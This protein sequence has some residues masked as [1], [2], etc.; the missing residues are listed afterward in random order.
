MTNEQKELIAT[1][2]GWVKTG[3]HRVIR[4]SNGNEL[5]PLYR[6]EDK[7]GT[8]WLE[9]MPYDT[10]W[11]WIM[12]VWKRI[13][14]I[15]HNGHNV[16]AIISE[17]GGVISIKENHNGDR[18]SIEIANTLNINYFA[19]VPEEE[20][21]LEDSICEAIIRFINWYNDNVLAQKNDVKT[22]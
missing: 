20:I 5:I 18:H 7:F 11:N 10:D 14:K 6:K 3:H 17:H 2:D 12:G 13:Q 9:K 4:N 1:F 22:V 8:F 21:S 15:W 19:N 16:Q